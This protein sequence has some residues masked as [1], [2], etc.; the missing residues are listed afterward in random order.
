MRKILAIAVVLV[1]SSLATF[2]SLSVVV[3]ATS[4]PLTWN[5]PLAWGDD[6]TYVIDLNYVQHNLGLQAVSLAGATY[7]CGKVLVSAS[8][9]GFGQGS[10]SYGWDNDATP[11][12]DEYD[13]AKLLT[14]GLAWLIGSPDPTNPQ[15]ILFTGWSQDY[16]SNTI[17]YM[18]NLGYK[19]TWG[20][21][22]PSLTS[23]DLSGYN[24]LMTSCQGLTTDPT[25]VQSTI[26]AVLDFVNG[27]GGF[28]CLGHYGGPQP[29]TGIDHCYEICDGATENALVNNFG[30]NYSMDTV[31]DPTNYNGYTVNPVYH[32]F[33]TDPVT[34]GLSEICFDAGSSLT[35]TL[36]RPHGVIPEVPLGTIMPSVAM[37]IAMAAYGA[38]PKRRRKSE[39]LKS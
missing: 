21:S 5:A 18:E 2:T 11:E 7:G 29:V 37:I 27:G 4:S 14:N 39:Y 6:D 10:I 19:V 20:G 36:V 26:N 28:W 3:K 32:N 33:A 22:F 1:L 9:E 13:N 30:I 34:Q 12:L 23:A 8:F 16:H 35:V 17:S 31:F 25:Y 24:M 15:K 38:V